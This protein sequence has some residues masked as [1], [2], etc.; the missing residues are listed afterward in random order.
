MS[1]FDIEEEKDPSWGPQ[2]LL[3][4]VDCSMW[5]SFY[6]CKC[7]AQVWNLAMLITH[8]WFASP[9]CTVDWSEN[10]IRSMPS[11]SKYPSRSNI[12]SLLRYAYLTL[13]TILYYTPRP[14]TIS[15]IQIT[16]TG[17]FYSFISLIPSQITMVTINHHIIPLTSIRSPVLSQAQKSFEKPSR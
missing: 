6:I 16:H 14:L 3:V 13:Y 15:H 4:A 12:Y 5:Y 11:T 9:L 2:I 7:T 1:C 17:T 8:N 10:I